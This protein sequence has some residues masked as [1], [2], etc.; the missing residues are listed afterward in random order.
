MLYSCCSR[1]S[2]EPTSPCLLGKSKINGNECNARCSRKG[3]PRL[4]L[5]LTVFL[6][7]S[8]QVENTLSTYDPHACVIVYSVVDRGSFA[9]AEEVLGYLWRI[10]FSDSNKASIILVANKVDLERS[11]QISQEGEMKVNSESAGY[12]RLK[13][14]TSRAT[15]RCYMRCMSSCKNNIEI[16]LCYK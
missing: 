7:F 4:D 12:K 3:H 13:G 10:G 6:L 14:F 2:P 15:D 5:S 16:Y 8:T 9:L 11:R 1:I